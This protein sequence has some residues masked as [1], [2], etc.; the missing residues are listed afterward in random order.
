MAELNNKYIAVS[1]KLYGVKNGEERELIEEATAKEPF[2]FVTELGMTLD[3][4]EKEI[5][6]LSEGDDFSITMTPQQA[7]GEYVEEGVQTLPLSMF[8]I[9]GKIDEKYIYEGA[10]VPLQ[11]AQGEHFQGTL[12]KITDK[13]VTVDLNHPL[14]GYTLTFEGKVL[15]SRLATAEELQ[16]TIKM[17]SGGCGGCGGCGG[18]DCNGGDCGHCGGCK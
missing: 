16:A 17:L 14:A 7:Y 2:K 18:G 3:D 4:F 5:A 15:T 9:D 11:N 8:E 6:P 13:E 10:V 1:Y 12:T